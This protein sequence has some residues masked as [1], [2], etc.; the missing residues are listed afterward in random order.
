MSCMTWPFEPLW[1][2]LFF[3]P[4]ERRRKIRSLFRPR[5]LL[6]PGRHD[7]LRE[8]PN[9]PRGGMQGSRGLSA[10]IRV[11]IVASMRKKPTAPTDDF[12][13]P[14][15][16]ALQRYLPSF[17]AFFF[18]DIHGE[19]D[20]SRGY[21][22]LDKEFQ[23]IVRRAKVG[24]RLADKLFKVWLTSGK[25]AWLLIH[26]EIQGSVEAHFPRRMFQY[27][28]RCFEKY[29]RRVISLAVLCD[30]RPKWRP[31]RFSYGGWGSKMELTF[32]VAKLLD[33]AD[34]QE[35]LAQHTNPLA[36]VVLAHLKALETR[37]DPVQRRQ[38]KIQLVKG[39]YEHGWSAEDVRQL[40]RLI[41][42]LMD[43][44]QE[45]QEGFREELHRYEEEKTMPYVSSVERLA[46]EEGRQE[47]RQ[48]GVREGLL[49]AI[50]VGLKR[51]FGRAGLKLLPKLRALKH[52]SQLCDV[53]ETL[54][55][56]DSLDA[57][58][59]LI[60]KLTD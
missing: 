6:R 45:L 43:L 59:D 53:T 18:A 16:D 44:P 25:E 49:K 8:H 2:S 15:K 58:R 23:Q 17:L 13:S 34:Q 21:E 39:L 55:T 57:I 51:R 36:H 29:H 35:A 41:D 48:E 40:F 28:Y 3:I 7:H 38:W 11:G 33:Y 32:P 47:G 4:H 50:E 56:A 46:K 30:E 20:W 54:I 60:S 22:A 19:V 31:H 9:G 12:D 42:W 10:R 37:R 14:W 5:P 52:D 1:P 27:N 26:V 24:K